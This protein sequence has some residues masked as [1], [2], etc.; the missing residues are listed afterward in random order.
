MYA[1]IYARIFV[2]KSDPKRYMYFSCDQADGNLLHIFVYLL[3]CW[4]RMKFIW[5][6][7]YFKKSNYNFV[8][9][10]F[11]L[12]MCVSGINIYT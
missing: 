11:I 8:D 10:V 5:M 3:L 6:Y 9:I 2:V 1:D 7:D 12:C 4:H